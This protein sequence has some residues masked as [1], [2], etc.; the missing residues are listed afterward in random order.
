MA[1]RQQNEQFR[2]EIRRNQLEEI[3]Q[4]RRIKYFNDTAEQMEPE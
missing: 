4:N 2:K 3:F 1:Y